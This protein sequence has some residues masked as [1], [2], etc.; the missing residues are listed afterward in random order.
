MTRLR[1]E[2]LRR[3]LLTIAVALAFALVVAVG[4]VATNDEFF[5]SG[6]TRP[7]EP[8]FAAALGRDPIWSDHPATGTTPDWEHGGGYCTDADD[9]EFSAAEGE[10]N[11][12][13]SPAQIMEFYRDSATAKGWQEVTVST[14]GPGWHTVCAVKTTPD[15]H[16]IDLDISMPDLQ[17]VNLARGTRTYYISLYGDAVESSC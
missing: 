15:G 6:A 4:I 16:H 13:L 2:T 5:A 8:D 3:T 12:T 17:P 7:C 1:P 9:G 10:Y 11:T 14:P